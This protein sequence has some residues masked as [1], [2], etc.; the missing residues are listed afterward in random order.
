M[1]DEYYWTDSLDEYRAAISRVPRGP[2]GP[3]GPLPT[4]LIPMRVGAPT[5]RRPIAAPR[6]SARPPAPFAYG[7][8]FTAL[9]RSGSHAVAPQATQ[10][11]KC[12]GCGT[13]VAT[14]W[15]LW[16]VCA[17]G[18]VRPPTPTE[19]AAQMRLRLALAVGER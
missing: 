9:D 6:T 13:P 14:P 17:C 15:L 11:K 7:R 16:N 10:P 19:E 2:C 8:R 5:L 3:L 12:G 18:R 1:K 4:A